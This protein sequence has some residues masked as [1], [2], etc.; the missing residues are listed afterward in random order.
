M[1][2]LLL[3]AGVIL[4]HSG[5]REYA[6]RKYA[7]G[8][9][10]PRDLKRLCGVS[11]PHR[12]GHPH[13]IKYPCGGKAPDEAPVIFIIEKYYNRGAALDLLSRRPGAVCILHAG[14]LSAAGVCY[15]MVLRAPGNALSKTGMALLVGGG[16]GNLCDRLCRGYVVDYFRFPVGP[17][18]FRRIIFNL[19]DLCVFAGALLAVAG[20]DKK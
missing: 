8:V 11:H 1:N 20:A 4:L 14:M 6:D 13:G 3:T 7:R 16:A 19:S 5:V 9:E 10:H 12:A 2:Y 18:R 17:E 15:A